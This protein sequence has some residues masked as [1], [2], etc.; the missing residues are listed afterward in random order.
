MKIHFY[1]ILILI[2]LRYYYYYFLEFRLTV[3]KWYRS[4]NSI[5]QKTCQTAMLISCKLPS[6]WLQFIKKR[7][8]RKNIIP[9]SSYYYIIYYMFLQLQHI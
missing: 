1:I 8:E 4:Q 6:L 3:F 7:N 2:L 5:V 9:I